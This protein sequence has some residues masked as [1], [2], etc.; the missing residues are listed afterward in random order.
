MKNEKVVR[1][2]DSAEFRTSIEGWACKE[3]DRVWVGEEHMAR[4][5]CANN[6]PCRCGGRI[7]GSIWTMC[8]SCREK[9]ED[10]RELLEKAT[11]CEYDGYPFFVRGRFY[12]DGEAYLDELEWGSVGSDEYGFLGMKAGFY[13]DSD[14]VI[15]TALESADID[16]YEYGVPDLEGVDELKKAIDLFNEKN[17]KVDYW[18]RDESRKFK[19]SDLTKK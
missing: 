16:V 13:V 2:E 19:L 10:Y 3:C 11:L 4:Y 5:C 18:F 1:Y 15:E 6:F 12:F 9:A 17:S 7:E 14:D 8:Q